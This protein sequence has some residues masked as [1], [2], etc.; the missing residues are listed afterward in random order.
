MC[1]PTTIAYGLA[2][3]FT[4]V[5]GVQTAQTQRAIGRYNAEVA[6]N[7]AQVAEQQARDANIRGARKADE[8]RLKTKLMIGKQRA[9]LAAQGVT[10]DSETSLDIL[11]DTAMFGAMD[12]ETIRTDAAREAWGY[13][14]QAT[15]YRNQGRLD[16]WTGNMQAR[17]TLLS[18][19]AQTF[20]MG[21]GVASSWPKGG[22]VAQLSNTKSAPSFKAF[23]GKG[24]F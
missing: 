3:V 10:L 23:G 6:E 1:E 4:V 5:A 2:T 17:G 21:A 22:Q 11:G 9:S 20:Q 12:E 18:T 19:A 14:V 8:Q 24:G 16:R 13:Q 15:N 7:N